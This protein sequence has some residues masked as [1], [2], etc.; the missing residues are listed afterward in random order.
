MTFV[1][2]QK[3]RASEL[4]DSFTSLIGGSRLAA[5]GSSSSGTDVKLVATL[6]SL[7]LPANSAFTIDFMLQLNVS[8]A[9]SDYV[10][11]IRPTD[12][13]TAALMQGVLPRTQD[14][15]PYAIRLSYGYKTTTEETST[16]VGCFARVAGTGTAFAGT[17][18]YLTVTKIGPASLFA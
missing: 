5:N 18:S 7:V 10:A 8:A 12:I 6:S 1:A 17:G 11:Q 16:F 13:T 9:G 3:L 2:G 14:A 4:N 15:Y